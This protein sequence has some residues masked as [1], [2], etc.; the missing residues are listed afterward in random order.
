MTGSDP[1][2]IVGQTI[3][4]TYRIESLLGEGGMSVVYRAVHVILKQPVA[5]KFFSV[6]AELPADQREEF[7]T[8]FVQEGALLTELSSRTANIVQA[9][10]TGTYVAPDGP[11]CPYLV[12]ELLEGNSLEDVL[13]AERGRADRPWSLLEVMSLLG[14][15]AAALDVAHGRGVSHRDIKPANLIIIG[16][17]PRLGDVTVKL[18]DFGVAKLVTGNANLNALLAKTGRS[19]TSFT[20]QYA[21]P[22][23][24]SRA[25]GA[26]GPWTDVFS[27]ALVAVEMMAGRRA[28]R[29]SDLAE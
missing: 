16:S 8:A 17:N 25:Y 4:R 29:G 5:I 28:L 27:L 13:H 2:G 9:R 23:Q 19:V 18:V 20:P 21:A 11:W 26:T 1:L 22:E 3:A 12:L 7:L 14:Q 6:L 10:D 24:F 15:A